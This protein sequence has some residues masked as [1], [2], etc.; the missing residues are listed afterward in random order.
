[1]VVLRKTL[2]VSLADVAGRT[3]KCGTGM[4]DCDPIYFDE[5]LVSLIVC[6]LIILP[7][8]LYRRLDGLAKFSAVSVLSVMAIAGIIVYE[9]G[10]EREE[11]D[12]GWRENFLYVKTGYISSL[13]TFIF[14]FVSQH[15][16]HVVYRSMRD[17]SRWSFVSGTAVGVA[18]ATSIVVSSFAYFTYW[19][20]TSSDLFTM[21]PP[22]KV[23]DVAELLLSVTM[24]FTYPMPF[25]TCRELFVVWLAMGEEE[26]EGEGEEDEEGRVRGGTNGTANSGKGARMQMNDRADVASDRS[27]GGDQPALSEDDLESPLISGRGYN[28]RR[29][30]ALSGNSN[31]EIMSST[32]SR[33][34]S[35]VDFMLPGGMISSNM[36]AYQLKTFYHVLLTLSIWFSTVVVAFVANELGT[37]LNLCGCISGSAIA[38]VLPAIFHLKLDK[39]SPPRTN[40]IVGFMLFIG[41]AVAVLGTAF[42]IFGL[43]RGDEDEQGDDEGV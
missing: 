24:L 16:S 21:Y 20:K 32:S 27:G 13:G 1:M 28:K 4:F 19:D 33:R 7:L 38:F 3:V 35:L 29:Q 22:S 17:R 37:V 36:N 41:I 15:T 11:S 42:E 8:C 43:V 6:T 26:E 5:T 10:E 39:V 9:Y 40:F 31:S 18:L 34:R 25:F 2:N 14:A 30:K 12:N 23:I